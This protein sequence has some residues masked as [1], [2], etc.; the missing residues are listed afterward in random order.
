M[1]PAPSQRFH[2][3][4][5]PV[6]VDAVIGRYRP[7]RSL[8]TS[9]ATTSLATAGPVP[10]DA[11]IGRYGRPLAR[12]RPLRQSNARPSQDSANGRSN[13]HLHDRELQSGVPVELVAG[14][15]LREP[16]TAADWLTELRQN[17]HARY[18]YNLHVCFV[19]EGRCMEIHRERATADA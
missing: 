17:A 11:V 8:T 14:A 1:V 4:A 2:A 10:V 7:R 3:T 18:W 16:I 6:P 15:L 5:G 12:P 13:P 9:L 19:N